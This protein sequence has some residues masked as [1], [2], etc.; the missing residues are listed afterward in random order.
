[1]R[2][3]SRTGA[4]LEPFNL[5]SSRITRSYRFSRSD[6]PRDFF[7]RGRVDLKIREKYGAN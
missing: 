2:S 4:R 1:M 5:N 3:G 6:I 7:K